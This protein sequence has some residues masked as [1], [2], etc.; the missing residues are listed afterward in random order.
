MDD[1]AENYTDYLHH[2]NELF[3]T[4]LYNVSTV[5]EYISDEIISISYQETCLSVHLGDETKLERNIK[6]M[7]KK[8][9]KDIEPIVPILFHD[10]F[11]YYNGEEEIKETLEKFKIWKSAYN[12]IYETTKSSM[13][14]EAFID[15]I[16]YFL[17]FTVTDLY[18]QINTIIIDQ[19]KIPPEKAYLK[20]MP[21]KYGVSLIQVPLREDIGQR[22]VFIFT[23]IA[24]LKSYII[25]KME[26]LFGEDRVPRPPFLELPQEEKV[27]LPVEERRVY[28]ELA[29]KPMYNKVPLG[30]R[31]C[32]PALSMKLPDTRWK[33][34]FLYPPKDDNFDTVYSEI[35]T[36][37]EGGARSFIK[38]SLVHDIAANLRKTQK[39]SA[40]MTAKIMHL[41]KSE[42]SSIASKKKAVLSADAKTKEKF[43]E[44]MA[45]NQRHG[46]YMEDPAITLDLLSSE[47]HIRFM[48]EQMKKGEKSLD[49]FVSQV[50]SQAQIKVNGNGSVDEV[51]LTP[52]MRYASLDP[53]ELLKE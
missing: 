46:I 11:T 20:G 25:T 24:P 27:L 35:P 1:E 14:F 4:Q 7:M 53:R 39:E 2:E 12:K 33:L 44:Q 32:S 31:T 23:S 43:I 9:Q 15:L 10:V 30:V 50:L 37:K 38:A 48:K 51:H 52:Q 49:A 28:D 45:E 42:Q 5:E 17:T 26:V 21:E 3:V 41:E 22:I 36:I 34:P 18:K 8:Y 13:F 6:L 40:I 19:N 47:E 29:P 16:P